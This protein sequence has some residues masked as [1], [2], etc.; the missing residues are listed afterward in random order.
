MPPARSTAAQRRQLALAVATLVGLQT[1]LAAAAL[2]GHALWVRLA[3]ASPLEA[4]STA[5]TWQVLAGDRS[6]PGEFNSPT[7]VT[8]DGEGNIYV[9]DWQNHRIQ[10][11]AAD[12]TPLAVWGTPGT[13]PGQFDQPYAISRD[14]Q[15]SLSLCGRRRQQ[16][17]SEALPHR[18]AAR[19]VGHIRQRARP[20][21]VP[22]RRRSGRGRQ[23]LRGRHRQLARAEAL[24]GR[25]AARPVGHPG[26]RPPASSWMRRTTSM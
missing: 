2:V 13:G 20:V 23:R 14:H 4:Q 21:P 3:T 8:V 7:G 24:A 22:V 26:Q 18:P 17:H 25:G 9:A 15:G 19:P 11:L 16:P 1:V 12:G 5:G 6:Q 10:K